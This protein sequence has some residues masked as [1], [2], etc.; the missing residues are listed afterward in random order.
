MISSPIS[1]MMLGVKN[2]IEA[3]DIRT[4]DQVSFVAECG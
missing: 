1:D 4:G 3:A 2:M